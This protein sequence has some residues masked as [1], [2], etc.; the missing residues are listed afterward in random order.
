MYDHRQPLSDERVTALFLQHLPVEK[1]PAH[2]EKQLWRQVLVAVK[3][4]KHT[5]QRTPPDRADEA[6]SALDQNSPPHAPVEKNYSIYSRPAD[7]NAPDLS[8]KLA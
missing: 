1:I 8:H 4:L 7:Q 2:V 5:R 3:E 6:S